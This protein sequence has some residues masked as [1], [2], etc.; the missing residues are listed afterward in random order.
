MGYGYVY[1]NPQLQPRPQMQTLTTIRSNLLSQAFGAHSLYVP[2][3]ISGLIDSHVRANFDAARENIADQLE[4]R[5]SVRVVIDI[6]R[7]VHLVS[8]DYILNNDFLA[9]EYVDM[10]LMSPLERMLDG[11]I[12]HRQFIAQQREALRSGVEIAN[13]DI[14]EGA[15]YSNKDF[16]AE[17]RHVATTVFTTAHQFKPCYVEF[18]DYVAIADYEVA[19]LEPLIVELI[20]SGT[21]LTIKNYVR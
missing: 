17:F 14:P 10:D 13:A 21:Y 12:D 4:A 9:Y 18:A 7:A 15:D 11:V 8:Y 5:D 19:E 16:P 1:T 3:E 20:R 6:C 2:A